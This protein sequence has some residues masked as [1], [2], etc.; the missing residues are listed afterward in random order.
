MSQDPHKTDEVPTYVMTEQEN[1][2]LS[3]LKLTGLFCFVCFEVWF[4]LLFYFCS[5]LVVLVVLGFVWFFGVVGFCCCFLFFVLRKGL[6]Y[7]LMVRTDFVAENDLKCLIPLPLHYLS[8]DITAMCYHTW[9]MWCWWLNLGVC[10]HW[11]TILSTEIPAQPPN[12]CLLSRYSSDIWRYCHSPVG[13]LLR[14]SPLM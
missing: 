12:F 10:V 3:W 5:C 2:Q 6:I 13:L 11:A 7:S 8:A 9:L 14:D 4:L 1:S